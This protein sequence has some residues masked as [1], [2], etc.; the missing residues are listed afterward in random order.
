MRLLLRLIQDNLGDPLKLAAETKHT[1][2]ASIRLVRNKSGEE[3]DHYIHQ[4]DI[5]AGAS[6]I[7]VLEDI[8]EEGDECR[9]RIVEY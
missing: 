4:F 1:L 6:I 9:D 5:G 3:V 7:G 8:S 2:D